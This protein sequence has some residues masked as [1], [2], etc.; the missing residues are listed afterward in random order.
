MKLQELFTI[1]FAMNSFITQI[2]KKRLGWHGSWD[3]W[4]EL[5]YLILQ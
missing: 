5:D 4:P 2:I 1:I 3:Y